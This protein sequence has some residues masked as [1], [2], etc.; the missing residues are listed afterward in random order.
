MISCSSWFKM[1]IL[2]QSRP[3]VARHTVLNAL[4]RVDDTISLRECESHILY[5]LQ[6]KL[7]GGSNISHGLAQGYCKSSAKLQVLCIGKKVGV[8]SSCASN[9]DS[10]LS[11]DSR[12]N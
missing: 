1:K 9:K 2:D 5:I 12:V 8:P 3:H 4:L 11:T 6:Y 7:P 10:R